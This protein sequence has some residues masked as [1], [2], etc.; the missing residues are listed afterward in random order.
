MKNNI[1]FYSLGGAFSLNGLLMLLAVI[2]SFIYSESILFQWIACALLNI[3]LGGVLLLCFRHFNK[4]ISKKQGYLIVVFGWLAMFLSGALPYLITKVE[5]N[6]INALFESI[7][8]YTT[9]GAT[10]F[11]NVEAL[12]KSILFWRSLTHW[13]GGMGIIVLA[14]TILPILGIGSVQLFSAEASGIKSDKI[15]PRIKQTATI[16]WSIY[17]GYT[18]L[19]TLFLYF[20]GMSFFDALN[21]AFST[22]SC[23]GFSTKNNSLAFWN[24]LPLI[25]YILIGFM[26]ISGTN[27]ILTFFLLKGKFH[28]IIADEE[29]KTYFIF[30]LLVSFLMFLGV[31]F[32]SDFESSTTDLLLYGKTEA[33]ARHSLFQ[34]L[35]VVTTSGFIISD[36][37]LWN[38]FVKVLIFALF[39][40]GACAGST[41]GGIKIVRHLL[42]AKNSF[43]EFKRA[44]H[45][46]A[47]IPTRLNSRAVSR[48]LM[49]SIMGFFVL[50]IM[51]FILGALI[52][53]LLGNDLITALSGSISALGNVGV[54]LGELSP[55]NS[56]SN[57]SDLSKLWC[58]FLMFV[59]RLEIFTIL[60]IFSPYFWKKV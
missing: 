20:G 57:L 34:T 53:G 3:S 33:V 60:I 29:F 13:I 12:P 41:S 51:I 37:N 21:H 19:L 24:H 40:S 16:L 1:L 11:S 32:H 56:Y 28:K 52:L 5:K 10:I 9:T 55:T 30:I 26:F 14:I 27:F 50:Y 22:I 6:I 59:G 25:H 23:G 8:G 2:T 36:Y 47:I 44:F 7:S 17:L 58:S 35:S 38:E 18:F 46:N 43:M 39:F 49:Y 45:P 31:Y 42:V 15:H 48:N 54:A 4:K